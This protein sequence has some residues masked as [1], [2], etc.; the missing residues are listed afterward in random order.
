MNHTYTCVNY[1]WIDTVLKEEV[2]R[3]LNASLIVVE[4]SNAKFCKLDV[5]DS[6][7]FSC[8]PFKIR[9]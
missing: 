3:K 9:Q 4:N 5:N 6:L 1:F 2:Y 7:P 8:K